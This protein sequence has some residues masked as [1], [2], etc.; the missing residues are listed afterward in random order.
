MGIPWN[1]QFFINSKQ[2]IVILTNGDRGA[3]LRTEIMQKWEKLMGGSS[4]EGLWEGE[5]REYRRI[6]L[7]EIIVSFV[8]IEL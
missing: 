6:G 1:L 4:L 7:I 2:G 8:I 5:Y 3:A